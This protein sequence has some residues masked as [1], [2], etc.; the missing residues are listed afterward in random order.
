[1]EAGR[2]SNAALEAERQTMSSPVGSVEKWP[3]IRGEENWNWDEKD[4][5]A[6][7][8]KRKPLPPTSPF[9]S[10]E[11]LPIPTKESIMVWA[12]AGHER[13]ARTT[14]MTWSGVCQLLNEELLAKSSRPKSLPDQIADLTSVS[15]SGAWKWPKVK[16][17]SKDTNHQVSQ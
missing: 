7:G 1:M 14:G 2:H 12:E 10:M 17:W 16:E 5:K 4:D 15:F 6:K 8:L 9:Y 13:A 3:Q 11:G